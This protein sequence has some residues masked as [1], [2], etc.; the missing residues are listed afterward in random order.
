MNWPTVIFLVFGMMSLVSIMGFIIFGTRK[1]EQIKQVEQALGKRTGE[2]E[3]QLGKMHK[4][5]RTSEDEKK[6]IFQR[7]QNLETIVSNDISEMRGNQEE[8]THIFSEMEEIT[9][10]T[11]TTESK[12]TKSRN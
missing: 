7:L 4:A 10:T 5:L 2:L 3:A 1:T 9:P 11:P 8:G 12:A 6:Q